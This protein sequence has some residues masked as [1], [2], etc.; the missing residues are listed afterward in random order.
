MTPSAVQSKCLSRFRTTNSSIS[1]VVR[2]H[3]CSGCGILRITFVGGPMMIF[4]RVQLTA[5]HGS[6][7]IIG[8]YL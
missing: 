4:L 8:L 3:D 2:L 5:E 7:T 6:N 1:V